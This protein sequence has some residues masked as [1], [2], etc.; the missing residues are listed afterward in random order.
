MKQAPGQQQ[1]KKESK[2]AGFRSE[3]FVEYDFE[4][5]TGWSEIIR[6]P[7]GMGIMIE[8][9]LTELVWSCNANGERKNA[10]KVYE[11]CSRGTPLKK[12]IEKVK[13]DIE[14]KTDDV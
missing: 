14:K 7:V 13:E 1:R 10:K 3:I 5:K 12:R 2:T 4:D 11:K 8:R 6:Q 9:E